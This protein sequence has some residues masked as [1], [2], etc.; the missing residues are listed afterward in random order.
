MMTCLQSIYQTVRDDLASYPSKQLDIYCVAL[1]MLASKIYWQTKKHFD[2]ASTRFAQYPASFSAITEKQQETA[3]KDKTQPTLD[4]KKDTY[5]RGGGR[6]RNVC[7]IKPACL[8]FFH[9]F[10]PTLFLNQ[11]KKSLRVALPSMLTMIQHMK[12]KTTTSSSSLSSS[13][14]AL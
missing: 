8:F 10:L 4:K 12:R 14:L 13:R 9:M 1:S 6:E 11:K 3:T 5:L 2:G 7:F